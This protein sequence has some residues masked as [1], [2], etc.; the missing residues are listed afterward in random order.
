MVKINYLFLNL[1]FLSSLVLAQS[2]EFIE[3]YGPV[4]A[5]I[6]KIKSDFRFRLLVKYNPKVTPQTEIKKRLELL[7]LPNN[8]KLQID[9][10]P[11]N[12]F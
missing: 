4:S 9:V 6:Y 7:R 11:I 5:A 8:L 1:F 10:D 3:I 2:D 12:F